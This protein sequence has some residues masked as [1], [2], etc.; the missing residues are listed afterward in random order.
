MCP[1]RML[2]T[3]EIGGMV[4]VVTRDGARRDLQYTAVAD[5]LHGAHL[6]VLAPHALGTAAA[7]TLSTASG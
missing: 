7:D 3:G 2:R 5:V 1:L 6:S 4:T